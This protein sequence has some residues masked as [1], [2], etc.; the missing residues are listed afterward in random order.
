[1]K[2]EPV[3][4]FAGYVLDGRRRQL[5]GPDGVPVDI[6]SR[7]FETLH[8]L[9]SHPH[10]LIEKHRLMKAVWPNSMV[11]ENNLN[12]QIST[13]R[14]LLGETAGEHR[15][16]VT[17]TGQG[18]RFVQNVQQLESLSCDADT[19]WTTRIPREKDIFCVC[20]SR[21]LTGRRARPR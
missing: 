6:S 17:V 20:S 11:E 21:C 8:Y 13:L 19:A 14:K 15:F 18:Y 7:A 16:I 12:Q 9:A 5:L 10:E 4:A 1:M 3:L 2:A